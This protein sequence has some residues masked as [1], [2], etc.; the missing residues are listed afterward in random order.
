MMLDDRGEGSNIQ[1]LIIQL[2]EKAKH[3]IEEEEK[4]RR[5][6]AQAMEKNAKI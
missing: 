6:K 3:A 4:Q 5:R 2:N 1:K